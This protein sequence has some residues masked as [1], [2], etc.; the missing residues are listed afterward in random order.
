MNIP[1]HS[2]CRRG[3]HDLDLW[4]AKYFHLFIYL[5]IYIDIRIHIYVHIYTYIC[6]CVCIHT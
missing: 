3:V 1:K 2:A 4:V 5:F 6:V